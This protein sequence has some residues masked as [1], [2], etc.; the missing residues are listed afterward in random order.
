[1]P[2]GW[3]G[4]PTP[5]RGEGLSGKT[6]RVAAYEELARN[7]RS[8]EALTAY[9][10]FFGYVQLHADRAGRAG[11]AGRRATSR[12]GSWSSSAC[13]RSSGAGSAGDEWKQ[14]GPK[15]A[16]LTARALAAPL[17]RRSRH[18]RPGRDDQRGA[19]RRHRRA[20]R[21]T[22]TSRRRSRRAH[23][24]TAACRRGSRRCATGAT[25]LPIIG[26]LKP[27]VTLDAG[28]RGVR[29]A[30]AADRQK[31]LRLPVRRRR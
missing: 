23:A 11:A 6:F 8:F 21:T 31:A 3:C 17:R 9:F 12:R 7:N 16:M 24:W 25:R 15:A 27:G 19:V 14:N 22:S 13:S 2:T 20:A 5:A 30:G 26:R 10:A 1:M 18:R 4:L 28:A 29:D